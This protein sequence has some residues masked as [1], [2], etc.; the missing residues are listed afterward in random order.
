MSEYTFEYSTGYTQAI[1]S[2]G[3]LPDSIKRGDKNKWLY[4]FHELS[5]TT[6]STN[7]FTKITTHNN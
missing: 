1:I 3:P 7:F 4:L 2:S 6:K 5:F